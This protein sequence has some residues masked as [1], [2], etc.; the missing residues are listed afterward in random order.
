LVVRN[1]VVAEREIQALNLANSLQARE[2]VGEF[3]RA[4]TGVRAQ[5]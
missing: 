2:L 1:G 4:P 5:V 3:L